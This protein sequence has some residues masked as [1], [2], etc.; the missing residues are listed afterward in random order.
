MP[1]SATCGSREHTKAYV[2]KLSQL[3]Q[4][5]G[6]DNRLREKLTQEQ[7]DVGDDVHTRHLE[8]HITVYG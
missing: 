5:D 8:T 2:G 7:R 6:V 1:T 4:L 3:R